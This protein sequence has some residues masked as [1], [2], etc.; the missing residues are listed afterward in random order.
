VRLSGRGLGSAR[1]G[2]RNRWPV[3]LTRSEST[4]DH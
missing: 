1:R 3:M 4:S 2:H